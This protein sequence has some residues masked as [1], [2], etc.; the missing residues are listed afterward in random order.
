MLAM[1]SLNSHFSEV[2]FHTEVGQLIIGDLIVIVLVV[3]EHILGD[4]GQLY[5]AFLEQ[6]N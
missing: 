1:Q 3:P 2:L 4:V 6:S 5:L